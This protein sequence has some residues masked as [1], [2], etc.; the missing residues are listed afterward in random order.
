M[1]TGMALDE[2]PQPESGSNALGS[3]KIVA[4]D[5]CVSSWDERGTNPGAHDGCRRS[6]AFEC[7]SSEHSGTFGP[8][9]RVLERVL[10]RARDA[11]QRRASAAPSAAPGP[12]ARDHT[13][14]V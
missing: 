6:D 13:R 12:T 8:T 7:P 3:L 10:G 5:H 2:D 1:L 9:E 4:N 14:D 11:R